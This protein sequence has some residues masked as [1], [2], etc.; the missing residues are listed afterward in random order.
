MEF[1]DRG[2][3]HPLQLIDPHWFSVGVITEELLALGGSGKRNV[4][5]QPKDNCLIQVHRFNSW[6]GSK[7]WNAQLPEGENTLCL[8]AGIGWIVAVSDTSILRLFGSN[9]TQFDLLRLSG[10]PVASAGRGNRLICVYHQNSALVESQNMS[11][12]L[13]AI[14]GMR[15]VLLAEGSLTISLTSELKWIGFTSSLVP[16]V[17]DSFGN[18]EVIQLFLLQLVYVFV[19]VFVG[20]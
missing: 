20:W 3:H 10:Y 7:E 9:G 5:N 12:S 19:L 8:A 1:H 6:D 14:S 16:A 13:L 4:S 17:L 2:V 15:F 11:F 18:F